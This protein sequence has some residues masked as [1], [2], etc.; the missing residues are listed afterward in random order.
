MS[1][2]LEI[3][4]A[5]HYWCFPGPYKNGSENWTEL[6]SKIVQDMLDHGLLERDC[7]KL[8][9]NTPALRVFMEALQA[10]P[11]PVRVWQIPTGS[12]PQRVS[13]HE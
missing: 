13:K 8:S 11:W 7:G 1:S 2:P 6:E 10:V 4:I 5:I 3:S 12:V 9:G